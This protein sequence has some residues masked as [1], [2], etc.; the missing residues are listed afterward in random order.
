MRD[1]M[2]IHEIVLPETEPETEWILG[3]AVQKVSP[4]YTHGRLQSVLLMALW[5]WSAGRGRRAREREPHHRGFPGQFIRF[6]RAVQAGEG[7]R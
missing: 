4:Y 3:R 7:L 1:I 2:S 6:A 5:N